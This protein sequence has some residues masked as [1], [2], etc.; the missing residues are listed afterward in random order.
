[1]G[2][3]TEQEL[4]GEKKKQMRATNSI[5][6]IKAAEVTLQKGLEKQNKK[7]N[8]CVTIDVPWQHHSGYLLRQWPQFTENAEQ[9][10]IKTGLF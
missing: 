3:I 6:L 10:K 5:K 4:E 2:Y 1:M 7:K 9:Q 8:V